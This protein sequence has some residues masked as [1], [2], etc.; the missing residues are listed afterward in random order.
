MLR[1]LTPLTA[2][3]RAIVLGVALVCA[4]SRFAALARSIWDWDEALFC[5]AMRGYDV[6]QHR[7][8]PPGFPLYIALGKLVRLVAT[9]DFRALQA[10]NIVA[11]MLLFPAV[12]LL[13][14][15][16]RFRVE[17]ATVAAALCA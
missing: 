1:E 9:S 4:A 17:T 12:F 6:G 7:P 11:G 13:A 10:I 5:L 16:L 8:H 15:E 3:Q 2:R 14:R